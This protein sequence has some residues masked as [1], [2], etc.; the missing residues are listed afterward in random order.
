MKQRVP[1][2][3]DREDGRR[4]LQSRSAENLTSTAC[5]L[6]L[7][8]GHELKV[9]TGVSRSRSAQEL[10]N[11]SQRDRELQSPSHNSCSSESTRH[12]PHAGSGGGYGRRAGSHLGPRHR[13]R[14]REPPAVERALSLEERARV[15]ERMHR[16]F[17]GR[18]KGILNG[19]PIGCSEEV[20]ER[21]VHVI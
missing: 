21:C 17:S 11:D 20:H 8:G 4:P 9:Q 16:E 15:V 12:H 10:I 19:L 14:S 18:R 2:K 7:V 6:S 3:N 13:S 5:K 1:S